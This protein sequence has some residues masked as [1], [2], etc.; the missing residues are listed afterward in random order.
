MLVIYA[1]GSGLAGELKA[2]HP[3]ALGPDGAQFHRRWASRFL[4]RVDDIAFHQHKYLAVPVRGHRSIQPLLN[5]YRGLHHPGPHLLS[6]N[7]VALIQPAD[8]VVI[9]Y[10][11]FLHVAETGGQVVIFPEWT[12][13]IG[14]VG[15]LDREAPVPFR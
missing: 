12:M 14:G 7:L 6:W 10:L 15:R 13:R 1:S 4:D 9:A 2:I 3:L 5:A 8:R 11:S